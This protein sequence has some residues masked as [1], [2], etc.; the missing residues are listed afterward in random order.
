MA[1]KKSQGKIIAQNKKAYHDY[2][3][4]EKYEAGIALFGTEVKSLRAGTVNLKDSYCEV[5]DGEL[6]AV[7]F[8]IS[9][10]DHGNIFNHEP[11]RDKKLLM[12]KKEI[13]KLHGLVA[14]KGFT[15]V[16]L[17]LYFSG[18]KVK[19]EIGLCRGKKLYDKRDDMAKNDAKRTME[20]T[21]KNQ[22]YDA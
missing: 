12:H 5:K 6:F 19:M 8:H 14:Q 18:S 2:F 15:L 20:R 11:M 17:S 13:L 1:Q 16:P 4:D 10:Y 7:G 9:P 21:F 3:V 22:R